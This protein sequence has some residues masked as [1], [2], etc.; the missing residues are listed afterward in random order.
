MTKNPVRSA[1]A[2]GA[3]AVLVL[4]AALSIRLPAD[5]GTA[6]GD[7][8]QGRSGP[9]LHRQARNKDP[10]LAKAWIFDRGGWTFVHLEGSP[11]DIGYQHGY[12]VADKIEDLYKAWSL[13]D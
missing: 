13:F 10:R 3:L 4:L 8:Q 11:A 12:L 7:T 1:A 5:A 9:A 2:V 6:A